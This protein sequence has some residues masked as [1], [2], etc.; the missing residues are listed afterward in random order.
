MTRFDDMVSTEVSVPTFRDILRCPCGY[1]LADVLTSNEVLLNQ[2][3]V[4]TNPGIW[5]PSDGLRRQVR[6]LQRRAHIQGA[7]ANQAREQLR[8]REYWRPPKPRKRTPIV[9][10]IAC[11]LCKGDIEVEVGAKV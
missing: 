10:I 2:G 11:L 5:R 3:Y 7:G 4:E 8:T 9:C 1:A 6:E